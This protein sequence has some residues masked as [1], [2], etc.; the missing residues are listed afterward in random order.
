MRFARAVQDTHRFK[1][2]NLVLTQIDLGGEVIYRYFMSKS[3]SREPDAITGLRELS[4][5]LLGATLN[6][7]GSPNKISLT[8]FLE[9]IYSID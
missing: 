3:S 4:A 8:D 5:A 1:K 9:L 6:V 2:G 7:D